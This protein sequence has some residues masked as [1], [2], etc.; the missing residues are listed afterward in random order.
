MDNLRTANRALATPFSLAEAAPASAGVY[1]RGDYD[2]SIVYKQG[3][4]V[5]M[6]GV[7]YLSLAD[8]NEDNSPDSSP[9]FWEA[10]GGGGG[11]GGSGLPPGAA[12]KQLIRADSMGDPE[13]ADP[14]D[15]V[16]GALTTLLGEEVAGTTFI[17]DGAGDVATSSADVSA[18]MAAGDANAAVDAIGATRKTLI[19]NLLGSTFGQIFRLYAP[20]A[21]VIPFGSLSSGDNP[22]ATMIYNSGSKTITA[23]V[24][25]DVTGFG[26]TVGMNVLFNFT[27]GNQ[28][29][30]GPYVVTNTGADDPGGHAAVFT[31]RSDFDSSGDIHRGAIIPVDQDVTNNEP[32]SFYT[33][34]G[35]GPFTLDVSNLAFV[36]QSFP[37][38]TTVSTTTTNSGSANGSVILADATGGPITIQLPGA[39]RGPGPIRVKKIDSSGNAVTVDGNASETIDGATTLSLA[40]Q[41]EAVTLW[42]DGSNWSVF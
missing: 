36:K 2:D 40:T 5:T 27:Q 23:G 41:Y 9:N 16:G 4:L 37:V 21:T 10:L 12:N 26:L 22:L 38:P 8:A 30:S 24:N 42:S 28:S 14:D 34:Q 25:A 7:A 6:D 17:A 31:R 11:G 1:P 18:F 15:V 20:V 13:W 35:S 39:D 19:Q 32:G 33:L 3:D 29:A